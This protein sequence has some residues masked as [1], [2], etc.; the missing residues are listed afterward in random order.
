MSRLIV[1]VGGSVLHAIL[2]SVLFS[3]PLAAQAGGLVLN[4]LKAQNGVQLSADE[5]KQLMPNAKVVSYHK[6]GSTRRWTN[7]P[8]GKFVASSDN[9]R[10]I[11]K[12]MRSATGQGTWHVGDNGT[13]CVTLDWRE[14]S[15]NWCR[16]IFK[17]GEKYYGVKTVNDGATI[18]HEFEFSK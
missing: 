5:L 14:R 3:L 17:V 7:E 9:R 4:D 12:L 1:C 10:D 6:E 16:Y 2:A 18:A 11:S 13:Y 8:D 15:E